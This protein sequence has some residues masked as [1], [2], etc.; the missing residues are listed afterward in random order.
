[1]VYK[2]QHRQR[3]LSELLM[4]LVNGEF[5]CEAGGDGKPTPGLSAAGAF[6]KVIKG[7]WAIRNPVALNRGW[8]FRRPCHARRTMT[9][10]NG[11]SF[12]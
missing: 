1:M 11:N 5:P 12:R 4:H 7:R 9:E 6:G 10:V 2:E 3:L 8:R